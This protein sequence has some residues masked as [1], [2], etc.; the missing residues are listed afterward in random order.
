VFAAGDAR[1]GPSLIVWAIAEGRSAAAAVHEYLATGGS[2]PAPVT[3]ASM[4]LAARLTPL[5]SAQVLSSPPF[6]VHLIRAELSIAR[7]REASVVGG[8]GELGRGEEQGA[9][10]VGPP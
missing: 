10:E 5:L 8:G 6:A 7:G 4:A 1:R 2:L 3:P 9:G